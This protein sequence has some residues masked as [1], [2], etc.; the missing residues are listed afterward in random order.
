MAQ[1]VP[2]TAWGQLLLCH[3]ILLHGQTTEKDV[4]PTP[5]GNSDNL[6]LPF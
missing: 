3:R 1:E 2:V 6:S 5:G 4:I